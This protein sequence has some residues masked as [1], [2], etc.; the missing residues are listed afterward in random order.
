[1]KDST[2]KLDA[3]AIEWCLSSIA[4]NNILQSAAIIKPLAEHH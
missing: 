2:K 1:M 3:K 4:I